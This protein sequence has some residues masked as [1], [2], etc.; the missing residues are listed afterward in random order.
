MLL[1]LGHLTPKIR[2]LTLTTMWDHRDLETHV[3]SSTP[4]H[5][6]G[7]MSHL[8]RG[9]APTHSWLSQKTRHTFPWLIKLH[10]ESLC[11]SRSG[12]AHKT[13]AKS[14]NKVETGFKRNTSKL[15]ICRIPDGWN[16]AFVSVAY[17]NPS[18]KGQWQTNN[19]NKTN[20][21]H[22]P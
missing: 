10:F 11:G 18:S 14:T 5:P 8:C 3:T 7:Q 21:K 15:C 9:Q 19:N 22:V 2:H 20:E 16:H 4:G 1:N 17:W 13:A 6:V 12:L